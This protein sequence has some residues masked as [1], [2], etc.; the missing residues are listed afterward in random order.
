M[1]QAMLRTA[2]LVLVATLIAA[3]LDAFAR[4]PVGGGGAGRGG[5]RSGGTRSGGNN[6][7]ATKG[8]KKKSGPQGAIGGQNLSGAMQK[9][10]GAQG[11]LQNLK[12]GPLGADKFQSLANQPGQK[13]QARDGQ[14]SQN[15]QQQW[16][17]RG[18]GAQQNAQTARNNLQNGEQPFTAGW[19]ADHPNAWQVAHPHADA[20]AAAT[21]TGVARWLGWAAVNDNY[22]DG[23]AYGTTYYNTYVNEESAS[24]DADGVTETNESDD[25]NSAAAQNDSGDWLTLGVYTVLSD[26]GEPT[27]RLLQLSVNRA[28]E[29]RG[30]Y[31]DAISD[32]SQNL[33]GTLDENS[34]LAQW[35]L[36]SNP[37]ITFRAKL[38]ELTQSTGTIEVDQPSGDTQWRV[39]RQSS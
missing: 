6:A 28:G 4:G 1:F 38:A 35:S 15:T 18:G 39:T 9:F 24:D 25:D 33:S 16:Q 7:L 29:I 34:Q 20:A 13:L 10:P 3:P 22:N 36:D 14:F 26:S 32:S 8:R 17:A 5:A 21:A 30:V 2:L 23:Y 27:S 19:Y 37:Q 12:N 31:Y 11:G